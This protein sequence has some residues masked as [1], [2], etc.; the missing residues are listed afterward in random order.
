MSPVTERRPLRSVGECIMC[1]KTRQ[2]L[3][4]ICWFSGS[5]EAR[6]FMISKKVLNNLLTVNILHQLVNVNTYVSEM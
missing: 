4:N 6:H 5:L 1:V 3:Y 2:L